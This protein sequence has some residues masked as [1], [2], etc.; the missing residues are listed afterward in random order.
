MRSWF[1]PT[2][3]CIIPG[4]NIGSVAAAAAVEQLQP[5]L[6][7]VFAVL[8]RFAPSQLASALSG[9]ISLNLVFVLRSLVLTLLL[10]LNKLKLILTVVFVRS[11]FRPI[12]LPG[13]V[14]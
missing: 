3:L 14:C 4:T 7:L 11:G 12:A 1:R 5:R 9:P 13:D 10:S 2:T 6:Q 8:R